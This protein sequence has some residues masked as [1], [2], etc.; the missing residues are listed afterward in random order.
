LE[1]AAVEN[2]AYW[3]MVHSWLTYIVVYGPRRYGGSGEAVQRITVGD[4][5]VSVAGGVDRFD[6]N[7]F[8]CMTVQL[9][10]GV[11]VRRR[12][13]GDILGNGGLGDRRGCCLPDA[14]AVQRD[15]GEA[16]N[17]RA[18][19]ASRPAGDIVDSHRG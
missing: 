10:G 13:T 9:V 15:I 12:G 4:R 8:R 1:S 16:G 19:L 17:S 18:G 14:L 5:G 6:H 11:P 7:D 2:P 3:R